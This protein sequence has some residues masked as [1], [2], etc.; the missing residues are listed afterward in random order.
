VY[1]FTPKGH[2]LAL[3]RNATALDF[4]FAV[5]TDVGT[6]TVAARVD[7][8]LVPLRQRLNSGESV[9]IMAAPAALQNGQWLEWVVSARCRT[10]IR[11]FLKRMEHEDGCEAGCHSVCRALD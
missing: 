8:K 4:A 11:H 3:P 10:A 6:H 5:H 9:E 7:K 2:I 1:V